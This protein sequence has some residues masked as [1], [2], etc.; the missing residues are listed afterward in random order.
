MCPLLS[1]RSFLQLSS[2]FGAGA[3]LASCTPAAE[4]FAARE[5]ETLRRLI[6]LYTNDEHGWVEPYGEVGGAA[7]MSG[8]WRR[9]EQ[10]DPAGPFLALSGG[11]MWTGPAISTWYKGESM[12]DLMGSMGYAA[13]ALGNHDFDFGLETLRQRQ[14]Q[15]PFPLLSAN[16]RWRAD[17][18]SPDFLR[19]Y[20]IRQVNGIKVGLVGLT[21]QGTEWDTQPSHVAEL[22]FIAYAKAL[23]EVVP[24]MKA[25]GAALLVLLGHLCNA[26]LRA[27]APVAAEL[28]ISILCGG[29]CHEETVESAE[30]VT[31]VQSGSF[32]HNYIRIALLF[33]TA[34][35]QVVE[36]D[37]SLQPNTGG[38]PDADLAEQVEA[39]H[40]RMPAE[41]FQGIGY[42]GARIG[43][44]TPQ[45]AR[46]V[47]APW[48]AAYP[49]AQAA[50]YSPRYVQT[51]PQ[52]KI[53]RAGI[54]GMLP[55]D[56]LLVDIGL[57][58]AQLVEAVENPRAMFGGLQGAE[59]AYRLA[60][61]SPLDPQA[62]YRVLIP[63]ALYDGGN[64]FTVKQY[65]P[66]GV[67]TALNWRDPIADW[68][69]ALN[70]TPSDPLE[71][72]L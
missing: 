26:E 21:T 28:G 32:M 59:G 66:N 61:G 45:M 6:L 47:T 22:D 7:G 24:Q 3:L 46:L 10:Y 23:R 35:G 57:S 38:R 36:L 63:Q 16:I 60:D 50:I 2:L 15:A 12:V 11:D 31:I 70:T 52:G 67:Y 51:L 5:T 62:V 34:S 14:A 9:Q 39:W 48:L 53:T 40:A 37:A 58:G 55:T 56:N 13:A 29:H 64:H 71:K 68:I 42:V 44:S 18:A 19:P 49:A 69:A 20:A 43:W 8:L 25:E 1:R 54:L 72:H 65:D 17:G 33:D 30:G 41:M 4:D 27:L